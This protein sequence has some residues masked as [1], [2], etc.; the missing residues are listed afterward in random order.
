MREAIAEFLVVIS[1]SARTQVSILLGL[2]LF[3][4]ISLVGS[5]LVGDVSFHGPLAPLTDIVRENLM[6]RYDKAAWLML[7]SFLLLAVKSYKRD[8]KRLLGD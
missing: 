3:V 8:R 2:A 5:T 1:Y 4:G 7:G 6:H